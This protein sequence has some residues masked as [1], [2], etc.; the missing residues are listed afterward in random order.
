[1]CVARLPV[2]LGPLA[3]LHTTNR[4]WSML[5][6]SRPRD[7]SACV[8]AIWFGAACT[9]AYSYNGSHWATRTLKGKYLGQ[10]PNTPGGHLVL[11]EQ[12]PGET[13]V[14]LT[15]TVY[16]IRGADARPRY[17]VRGK[18]SQDLVLRAILAW[19]SDSMVPEAPWGEWQEEWQEGEE[20]TTVISKM[21]PKEGP[22]DGAPLGLQVR[23]PFQAF[24]GEAGLGW[25]DLELEG[26]D[27]VSCLKVLRLVLGTRRCQ[28]R[29]FEAPQGQKCWILPVSWEGKEIL[30]CSDMEAELGRYL[31][32]VLASWGNGD[33]WTVLVCA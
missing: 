13:K 1:M 3:V 26:V 5:A 27:L 4:H 16:P 33:H 14:L 23:C 24:K 7:R 25:T 8:V 11:V 15:N 9:E 20:T 32:R 19:P 17:R 21:W 31:S 22:Q 29:E 12:E 6:G 10:A 28:E 30:V 18:A 2:E